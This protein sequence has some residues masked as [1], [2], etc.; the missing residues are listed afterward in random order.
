[1][2]YQKLLVGEKPY[3][4]A[5]GDAVAFGLHR[6]PEVELSYCMEGAYTVVIDNCKYRLQAGDLMIVGPMAAHEFPEDCTPSAYRLTIELGPGL[7]GKHFEPVSGMTPHGKLLHLREEAG[8][9]QCD[10]MRQ[11]LEETACLQAQHTE[12]F[13]L[14][15]KGNLYKISALLL[16]MLSENNTGTAPDQSLRDVEKIEHS[17]EIIYNQYNE[18]L[19]LEQVCQTCGYSKSNFCKLFKRVTGDTFHNVLTRHRVEIACLHLKESAAS[20][21][22][23]AG[24]VGFSD[25]K[26]FC[27]IF[28]KFTG[29]TPGSYRKRRTTWK[30][31]MKQS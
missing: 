22:E 17:L 12:F 27:R 3:F 18:P 2:I 8:G 29:E 25:A 30:G 13:D 4:I 9:A 28:K 20:V 21:E 1:M 10:R 26:N 15:I 24:L 7:L 31:K 23:I 16:R 19:K 11:L 5:V 14:D 6:H